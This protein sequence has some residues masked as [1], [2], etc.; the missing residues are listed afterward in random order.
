MDGHSQTE[1]GR[2]EVQAELEEAIASFEGVDVDL[3]RMTQ[4]ASPL[5]DGPGSKEY[6]KIEEERELL[7]QQI[8]E[9]YNI[10]EDDDEEMF[11]RKFQKAK[12][13]GA[14]N[15]LLLDAYMDGDAYW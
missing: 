15:Q 10:S 5:L 7:R 9:K 6:E 14:L 4:T 8:L 11:E 13:D 12:E 2:R 1:K 3:R